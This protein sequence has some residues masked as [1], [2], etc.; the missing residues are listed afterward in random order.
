MTL[1]SVV[2]PAPLGPM[3]PSR[4]PRPTSSVTART[5]VSPPKRLVTDSSASTVHLGAR[6]GGATG[7]QPRRNAADAV[8][9]EAHDQDQRGA[10][11]HD[12]DAGQP[13]LHPGEPG[14]QIGLE[15]R[16]QDGPEERSERR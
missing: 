7:A 6:R 8:G 10:V 11:D 5:A 3:I 15:R 12:I 2:L 14:A 9:R 13:G 4:S 16:D 1:K